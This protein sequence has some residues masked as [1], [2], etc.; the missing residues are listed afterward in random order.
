M[1]LDLNM[2]IFHIFSEFSFLFRF[3]RHL[4]PLLGTPIA[5]DFP[6]VAAT[7]V[8]SSSVFDPM[9]RSRHPRPR[10]AAPARADDPA[11]SPFAATDALACAL[12]KT[13]DYRRG[14]GAMA[15]AVEQGLRPVGIGSRLIADDL[16]PAMRSLSVGSSRSATPASMA[17]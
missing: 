11:Y 15:G 17:S 1:R 9:M 3:T 7:S 2:L 5:A 4:S 14:D 13:L 10:H 8:R 6:P 16:E 12:G